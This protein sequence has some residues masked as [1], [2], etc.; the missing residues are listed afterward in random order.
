MK[1]GCCR[2]LSR[3]PSNRL[4]FSELMALPLAD[5]RRVIAEAQRESNAYIAENDIDPADELNEDYY[6][7]NASE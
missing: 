3:K 5:R 6:E 4:S 7:D 1:C 2:S